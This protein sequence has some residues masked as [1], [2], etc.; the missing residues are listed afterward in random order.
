MC[1]RVCLHSEMFMSRSHIF[2]CMCTHIF[3]LTLKISKRLHS[4]LQLSN[5]FK[6]TQK[7]RFILLLSSITTFLQHQYIIAVYF[8]C[9]STA[10]TLVIISLPRPCSF[11]LLF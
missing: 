10:G 7:P 5:R 1:V 9:V 6:H 2:A 11:S 3:R 4:Q 8:V